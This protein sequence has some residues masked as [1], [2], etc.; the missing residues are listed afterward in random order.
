MDRIPLSLEAQPGQ[1]STQKPPQ[2][3]RQ[4]LL[5][6][7][8]VG[9]GLL[10]IFGPGILFVPLAIVFSLLALLRGQASWAFAGIILAVGGF[11]SSP[12]LMGVVG[13]GAMWYGFDWQHLLQPILHLFDGGKDV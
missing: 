8:A 13:L 6:W 7:F 11:L 4:P 1:G 5:G 3:E 10:G 2:P 12:L 9:S